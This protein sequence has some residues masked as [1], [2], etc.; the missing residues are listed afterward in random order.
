MLLTKSIKLF[1]TPDIA[2]TTTVGINTFAYGRSKLDQNEI[3]KVRVSS[4]YN[5]IDIPENTT[6][7]KKGTTANVT[8]YGFDEDAE[9]SVVNSFGRERV[10]Y[11]LSVE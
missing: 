5:S 2:D 4:V 6:S 1:V 3:I 9:E 10:S 11:D 8:T 7:F